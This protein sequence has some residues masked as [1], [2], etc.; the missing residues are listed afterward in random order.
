MVELCWPDVAAGAMGDVAKLL[1][2][3]LRPDGSGAAALDA[4]PNESSV[5]RQ[6]LQPVPG[7]RPSAKQVSEL[8]RRAAEIAES[9]ADAKGGADLLHRD[10][11]WRTRREMGLATERRFTEL[12]TLRAFLLAH[13]EARMKEVQGH[14]VR[15]ALL[16][17]A[18]RQLGEQTDAGADDGLGE[19]RGGSERSPLSRQQSFNRGTQSPLR[20]PSFDGGG[21]VQ[22][23]RRGTSLDIPRQNSFNNK[24]RQQSFN[25]GHAQQQTQQPAAGL[26]DHLSKLQ[27][28]KKRR[29]SLDVTEISQSQVPGDAPVTRGVVRQPSFTSQEGG[30][31]SGVGS[32]RTSV[33]G[34]ASVDGG[35]R[36]SV[37][38]KRS[39]D[40]R[41]IQGGSPRSG[42]QGTPFNPVRRDASR[43][44]MDT[45]SSGGGERRG[46]RAP[47]TLHAK[48]L[49]QPVVQH[50]RPR[51]ARA[52]RRRRR[53]RRRRAREDVQVGEG[54]GRRGV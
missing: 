53:R 31:A 54:L 23:H 17:Y 47:A 34:R 1:G 25:R 32:P 10:N 33:D 15:S 38:R 52:R 21:G 20:G 29:Q 8:V 13:R 36:R 30:A 42:T 9:E 5:A 26:P 16:S 2:A 44:S 49:V 12:I 41:G 11:G 28:M 4:D 51:Q 50:R 39:F 19:R 27:P 22:P 37:E 18:L 35:H 6:L 7:N 24:L 48:R 40:G 46:I 3:T 45:T 43:T 14:R